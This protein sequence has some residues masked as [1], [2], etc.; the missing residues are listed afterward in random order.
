MCKV[1][2]IVTA[3]SVCPSP[4]LGINPHRQLLYLISTARKL[5]RITPQIQGSYPLGLLCL[6]VG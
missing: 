1:E 2:I 3:C 4:H 5:H 6:L